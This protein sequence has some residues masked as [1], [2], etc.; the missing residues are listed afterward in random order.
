MK[1]VPRETWIDKYLA[2]EGLVTMYYGRIRNGKTYAATADVLDLLDKGQRVV[3]NWPINW[4]GIDER[5]QRGRLLFSTITGVPLLRFDRSNHTYIPKESVTA[6]SLAA[7]TDA[8]IFLDE[9]QWVFDSYEK[10]D[11]AKDKRKLIQAT[12]HFRRSLNII[13]QRPTAIQ[14]TAR[15]QVNVFYKCEKTFHFGRWIRFKR[16]EFQDMSMETVDETK[17]LSEKHYW[18][19]KRVF[20]AYNSWYLRASTPFVYPDNHKYQLSRKEAFSLL[21]SSALRKNLSVNGEIFAPP[22]KELSTP[23]PY[24]SRLRSMLPFP[25]KGDKEETQTP[26]TG[27]QGFDEGA[28]A[29]NEARHNSELELDTTRE[30]KKDSGATRK[31][32][33][34]TI[35]YEDGEIIDFIPKRR[36]IQPI[37]E[38][39]PF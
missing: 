32:Q 31:F 36:P 20:G 23:H 24:F 22:Q 30:K 17:P 11:F 4:E 34:L 35:T 37:Q 38:E 28:I 18:G 10:T 3:T 13:T 8:H 14:V 7:F 1:E 21:T 27:I 19:N 26:P 12:G 16:T 9:G 5:L 15:A 29:T 6:A 2:P 39:L 25:I 33:N